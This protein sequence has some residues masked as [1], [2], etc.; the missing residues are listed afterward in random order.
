MRKGVRKGR[1][2]VGKDGTL[3]GRA[4]ARG[5]ARID[6]TGALQVSCPRSLPSRAGQ[7]ISQWLGGTEA[8]LAWNWSCKLSDASEFRVL[9]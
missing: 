8:G 6:G 2:G 7:P 1:S 9:C 4:D 3:C 5:S